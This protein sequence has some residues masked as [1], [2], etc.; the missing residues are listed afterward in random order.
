MQTDDAYPTPQ[1]PPVVAALGQLDQ[2]AGDP[3]FVQPASIVLSF[4]AAPRSTSAT[5]QNQNNSTMTAPIAVGSACCKRHRS[6]DDLVHEP[7]LI[8]YRSGQDKRIRV[9]QSHA[10]IQIVEHVGQRDQRSTIWSN[11]EGRSPK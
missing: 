8:E 1:P 6:P 2:L 10:A 4:A 11:D 9:L 3:P 5:T 7:K